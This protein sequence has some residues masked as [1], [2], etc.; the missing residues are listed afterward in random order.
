[1]RVSLALA[2]AG[3]LLASTG[4]A[5]WLSAGAGML[6]AGACLVAFALLR[7]TGGTR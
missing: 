5:V 3:V 6:L 7:E 2:A 1:M 4:V